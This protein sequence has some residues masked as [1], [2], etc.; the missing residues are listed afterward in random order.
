MYNFFKG[1][2]ISQYFELFSPLY[3]EIV[4]LTKLVCGSN[5]LGKVSAG[6]ATGV[7]SIH[8][9]ADSRAKRSGAIF[10]GRVHLEAL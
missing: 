2:F 8:Y 7:V 6:G 5:L 1:L 3:M 4:L 9:I 10:S